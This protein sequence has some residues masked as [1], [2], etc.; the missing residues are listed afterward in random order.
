MKKWNFRAIAGLD[1]PLRR[2]RLDHLL[3]F[4]EARPSLRGSTNA[5]LEAFYRSKEYVKSKI[6]W[7]VPAQRHT[8]K[9][10]P[11]EVHIRPS[12]L[13][14]ADLV[15][16]VEPGPGGLAL[17]KNLAKDLAADGPLISVVMPTHNTPIVFLKEAIE[18]VRDQVYPNWELCIADDASTDPAVVAMLESY[19][20][21]DDRIKVVFRK[22]NEHI[23][24]ASNS[25]LELA[26]GEYVALLDHDDLLAGDALL[27]V[28]VA[29]RR[30]PDV[31][32]IYTDEDKLSENNERY[33]PFFKPDWS[34]ESFLS[35]MYTCHLGVYRTA[36]MR[37]I[38]GFRKGFEGSQDY[39]LVLRLTEQTDKIVHIPR[40]LYHWRVHGQS[41]AQSSEAKPYA[42]VAAKKALSEAL[43][44]RKLPGRVLDVPGFMG[45]YRVRYDLKAKPKI[46]IVIPTRDFAHMLDRC[47][48]SLFAKTAYEN[49]EV[50]LVD[51]GSVRETTAKVLASWRKA[52]PTR[53]K[54]IREDS[55]FNFSRLC[56]LGAAQT[57]APYLLFLNNDTEIIDADWLG[58]MLEYAQQPEI[59]AVGAKLLYGNHTIQHVGVVLGLGGAA[60]HPH[61]LWARHHG[62]Y[63]GYAVCSNNVSAVTAACL[64]VERSKFD[65]VGGFDESFVVAFN[66]VDLCLKLLKAG[67]RNVM[68]P[69]I[70]VLHHESASRGNEFTPEKWSRLQRERSLLQERWAKQFWRDPYYNPNLTLTSAD[71]LVANRDERLILRE[72]W[73]SQQRRLENVELP[74]R[75]ALFAARRQNE[76]AEVQGDRRKPRH[77]I[78]VA[79]RQAS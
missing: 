68:L 50:V 5:V 51:N 30:Q 34:P 20:D 16:D 39:D 43:V 24:A 76:P 29:I 22:K 19:A 33:A 8:R 36:L 73:S 31:D 44:R 18:S 69:N 57:D 75:A 40:V 17:L 78:H 70:E 3:A 13:D 21:R 4:I 46:G 62:G 6:G 52:E 72:Q 12:E 9:V 23:S 7:R 48:T 54:V 59:G 41:T 67:F 74:T 32:M 10:L 49:F 25:A 66:D 47:L 2:D 42:Y 61:Q 58:G 55:A 37:R 79:D 45:H 63:Y 1:S 27:H 15:A 65:E 56:N 71:F 11:R 64:L 26:T 77:G 14:Y 53:F 28:A 60:G 38:G 35:R